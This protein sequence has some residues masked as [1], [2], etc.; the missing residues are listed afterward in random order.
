MFAYLKL[1]DDFGVPVYVDPQLLDTSGV[2]FH[3]IVELGLEGCAV[4]GPLGEAVEE[5]EL[6][7]ALLNESVEVIGISYFDNGLVL[8]DGCRVELLSLLLEPVEDVFRELGVGRLRKGVERAQ[9]E[10]AEA[11]EAEG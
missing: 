3:K 4:F 5:D 11:E 8:F 6:L 7:P 2:F 1:S 10:P 9:G